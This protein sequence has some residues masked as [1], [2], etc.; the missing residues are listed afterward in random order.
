[1]DLCYNNI[2]LSK[3]PPL[4][5]L[6]D[7]PA[8]LNTSCLEQQYKKFRSAFYDSSLNKQV[9]MKMGT[10]VFESI[11][12]LEVEFLEQ[13]LKGAIKGFSRK[14]LESMNATV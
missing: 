9:R 10:Q 6:D 13:V 14:E 11:N 2:P 7:A 1:V 12:I 5:F 3:T 4:F 8:G